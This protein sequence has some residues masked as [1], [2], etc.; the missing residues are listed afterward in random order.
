MLRDL[1]R[2]LAVALASNSP[3]ETLKREAE[4]LSGEDRA[5][6]DSLDSEQFLLSSL[7]VRK[8]RFERICRGDTKSEEW[9]GRDPGGFTKAFQSYNAEVPPVEFFPRPEAQAFRAWC[10]MKGIVN[11]AL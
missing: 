11:P 4:S 6:I 9:F 7:L 1:Q 10:K 3:L 8:L 2:V 5:A